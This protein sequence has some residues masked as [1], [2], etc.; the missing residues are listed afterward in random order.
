MKKI[1]KWLSLL[2]AV[3]V[4]IF[5]IF[6]LYTVNVEEPVLK[7]KPLAPLVKKQEMKKEVLWLD[8]FVERKKKDY[9]FPIGEIYI[10]TDLLKSVPTRKSFKITLGN[11]D[12]YQTFCLR[13]ELGRMGVRYFLK[14]SKGETI[15]RIYS[16]STQKLNDLIKVL[17]KYHIDAKIQK[18]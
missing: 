15:L 3:S 4:A 8:H 12:S 6:L 18:R 17:K 7:P 11:L 10:K 1:L 9:L 16:E 13:E 14:K 2:F 5:V